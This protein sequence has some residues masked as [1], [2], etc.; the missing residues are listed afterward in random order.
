[1]NSKMQWDGSAGLNGKDE[2]D[3]AAVDNDHLARGDIAD[4]RGLDQVEGAGLGS[5][6]VG[7]VKFGKRERPES[8]GIANG[9][10]LVF[11]H[12][13]QAVR[14]LDM[15]QSV[16]DPLVQ[17]GHAGLGDQVH[18]HFR[19]RGGREDR[20][21]G[22]K[23]VLQRSGIHQVPVMGHC[24]AA[25]CEVHQDRL[26]IECEASPCGGIAVMPDGHVTGKLFDAVFVEDVG[27][28]AHGLL[29]VQLF[30]VRRN[31]ACR[32]LAPVLERI[33]PQIGKIGGIRMAEYPENTA[34]FMELVKHNHYSKIPTSNDIQISN[35][36]CK[37]FG[38]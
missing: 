35:P 7:T 16:D 22:L 31:D 12:D 18:D 4:I 29:A 14:S 13:E 20:S 24:Q 38:A 8:V 27:H 33:E 19:V 37:P 3:A 32:L 5:D 21:I 15:A 26:D 6:D 9:D 36:T 30:A 10:Q 2:C 34:F 28:E 25:E 1:M 17:R 23:L 11:R